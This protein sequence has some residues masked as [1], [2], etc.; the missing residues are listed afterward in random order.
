MADVERRCIHDDRPWYCLKCENA[1]LKEHLTRV[2]KCFEYVRPFIPDDDKKK[3]VNE[4]IN[5]AR[6]ELADDL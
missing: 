3:R 1:R 6:V 5:E 4:I 2:V